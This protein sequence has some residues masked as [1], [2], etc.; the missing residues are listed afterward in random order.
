[1]TRIREPLGWDGLHWDDPQW[2]AAY[3]RQIE[4]ELL[5]ERGPEWFREYQRTADANW[6]AALYQI[7]A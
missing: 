2:V 4:T 7:G 3:R 1:M 6:D 5:A